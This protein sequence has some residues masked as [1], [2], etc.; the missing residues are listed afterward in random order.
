[1]YI[2]SWQGESPCYQPYMDVAHAAAPSLDFMG[3]D[4]YIDKGFGREIELALRPWNNAAIPETNSTTA[5]GARAW[6]AYCKYGCLYFG[7]YWGPELG[8]SRCKETF[9][10]LAEMADLVCEK[11][12][13]PDM[14][15]FHQEEEAAGKSW[16]ESVGG[17]KLRLTTTDAA[18]RGG[19]YDNVTGGEM[20]GAGMAMK[21]GPDEF[22]L[23]ASRL[24]VE[25][26][27]PAGKPLAVASAEQGRFEKNTWV[28]D[29]AFAPAVENG[30]V[31]FEFPRDSGKYG[32]VRFKLA[33]GK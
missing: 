5:A 22:V 18:K 10:I 19:V 3:P 25:W 32:Q 15:G 31:R 14:T 13:T 8:T 26:R 21:V 28:K 16:E 12:A 7:S 11:K 24:V 20:P 27:H 2:N 30:V 33:E 29:K 4:L 17:Y 9:E 23:I 1:M 6:T